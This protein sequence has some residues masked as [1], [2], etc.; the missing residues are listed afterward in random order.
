M[1]LLGSFVFLFFC[2]RVTDAHRGPLAATTAAP[3]TAPPTLLLRHSS[4][5]YPTAWS[6]GREG[7]GKQRCEPALAVL[8]LTGTGSNLK[9]GVW[10]G[11]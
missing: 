2:R 8:H 9:S 7:A 6:K 4:P 3:P 11:R 5:N 10:E 1:P